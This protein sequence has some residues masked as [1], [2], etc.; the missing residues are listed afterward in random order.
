MFQSFVDD[1]TG[2][3]GAPRIK[4]LRKKLR[5]MGL[6]GFI[7]PRED[8]FQGEYVPAAHDRL[9]WLTGFGGSA[10][11]AIIMARKAALF[12]DGRYILQAP[13]QVDTSVLTIVPVI[14][15]APS[16][17][18][19]RHAKRG[20]TIG[21]DP[22]LHSQNAVDALTRAAKE[23]GAKIVA[24]EENLVDAVWDTRPPLPETEII[25]QPEKLT[26]ASSVQ[27]R[28]DLAAQIKRAGADALVI[29]QPENIA[30]AL[31][32]RA[33]DVPHTPFALSFAVLHR[34]GSLDWYIDKE[35][36]SAAIKKHI[37]KGLRLKAS[38]TLQADLRGM[39]KIKVAVDPASTPAWFFS[40]LKGAEIIRMKDPC[41]LPKAC[42]TKAEIAGAVAAHK[43][44]GVALCQFLHWFD[45]Q[46]PKGQLSE[47]DAAKMAEAFRMASGKLKDLSF[48]TIAGSGPNGAI[49]HYRV[50]EKTNR[51]IRPGDLFLMDS[52]GQ[53]AQ[54]TT[55]VTRTILV[56]GK[57][58][59]KG[60]IDAF[61]RVLRGHIALA[62]ARF[63]VGTNGLQL[64]TLARAPLWAHG[65]DFDHGTGHGVGSYLSVH[66]GPQRISKGGDVALQPGMIVS[67][68]PGFYAP[69][70]F[71]IRIENLQ[72][73]TAPKGGKNARPM[74]GFKALT[75]APIDRRL[76]DASQL[77][78]DERAWLNSYHAEVAKTIGPKLDGGAARWLTRMCRPL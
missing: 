42:K 15:T 48:D 29:T 64:D 21:I 18:L 16:Q 4:L 7:V 22:R 25:A 68:E 47:I 55:D 37:G 44:D 31:N 52:G 10:G 6:D 32:I 57:P 45:T 75:L 71:G 46:A 61:T 28:A 26:G 9:K 33:D 1:P 30:W 56:R 39:K 41:A 43:T 19:A 23:A 53:Y 13:E 35:R 59:V 24:V 51:A 38:A 40:Q 65:Q 2:P 54:G 36:V 27:K 60:A 20:Q 69:G 66:E 3:R 77:T 67:N 14:E 8:E 62:M 72:Y 11:T 70:H 49:V 34:T 50:T 5:E 76:I 63:P 78:A 73:V 17:W 12:V 74:L 58:P